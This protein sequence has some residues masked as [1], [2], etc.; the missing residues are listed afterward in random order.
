MSG[1]R[2]AGAALA[3]VISGLIKPSAGIQPASQGTGQCVPVPVTLGAFKSLYEHLKLCL[4]EG[5]P[6]CP[7]QVNGVFIK[8]HLIV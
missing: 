4:V 5:C 1:H 3:L 7:L 8:T 2:R 6:D